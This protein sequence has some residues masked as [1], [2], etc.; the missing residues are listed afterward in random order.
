M[1]DSPR[2]G[3]RRKGWIPACAGMTVWGG[4]GELPIDRLRANGGEIR[5]LTTESTEDTEGKRK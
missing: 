2:R 5:G 1:G 3:W 4:E